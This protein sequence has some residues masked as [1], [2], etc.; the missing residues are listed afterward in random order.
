MGGVEGWRTPPIAQRLTSL[1][2]FL[3]RRRIFHS[4][5]VEDKVRPQGV[6]IGEQH[7]LVRDSVCRES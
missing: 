2:L 7:R 3:P 4:H 5:L 1:W 6:R